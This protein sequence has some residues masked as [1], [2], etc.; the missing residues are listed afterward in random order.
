MAI[1][2]MLFAFF[3][4]KLNVAGD[5]N[6][7]NADESGFCWH[8]SPSRRHD[9]NATQNSSHCLFHSHSN[10]Y[11]QEKKYKYAELVYLTA[12]EQN[13]PMLTCDK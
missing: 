3:I 6:R 13:L 4:T 8:K 10:N 1:T 7:N 12:S 2:V 5:E 11:V 9:A